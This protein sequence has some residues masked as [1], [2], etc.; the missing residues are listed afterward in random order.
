MSNL[1]LFAFVG[2]LLGQIVAEYSAMLHTRTLR[3]KHK[4]EW[5]Y[6][7]VAVPF[8]G[9]IAAAIVECI[10]SRT[11]P[12]VATVIAGSLL[13]AAG[14]IVRVWGHLELD[15]AF[16]PY[17]ETLAGQRLVQSGMYAKVRHP[18][19]LG[20]ILL[21]IGMPLV[22][23]ATWAWIFSALGMVGIIIRI[24]KEEAFL[25]MELPGYQDYIQNTWRLV[26]YVY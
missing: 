3:R 13:T 12:P 24:R 7:A 20:S 2:L 19:Y 10:S 16:S 5:T 17:V 9:M 26:P 8:K 22:L 1:A 14:I 11:Q 21:F 4:R 25:A 18:I 15:G 23:A 6:Y